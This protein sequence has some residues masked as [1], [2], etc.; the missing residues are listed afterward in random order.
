MREPT[1]EELKEWRKR[2]GEHGFLDED[3]Q[4][5]PGKFSIDLEETGENVL[6]LITPF[7]A[8]R[9]NPKTLELKKPPILFDRTDQGKIIFWGSWII[10][11]LEWLSEAETFPDYIREMAFKASRSLIPEDGFFPVDMD[12]IAIVLPDESGQSVLFE[13]LPPGLRLVLIERPKK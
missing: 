3:G 6:T 5:A 10:D 1:D 13:A 11:F 8:G 7:P 9:Y 12:T 4:M 2:A